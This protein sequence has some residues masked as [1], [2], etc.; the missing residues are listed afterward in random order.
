MTVG[1]FTFEIHLPESGSLKDRRQVLRSLK[2]RLR[3]RHNVA[4]VEL[5]ELSGLWQR[6]GLCVVSAAGRQ[7]VLEKLFEAVRREAEEVVPGHVMETGTD[8]I[9]ADL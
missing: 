7:D 1:V 2:E 9:E 6:A 3:A 5:E 4:V 8:Y